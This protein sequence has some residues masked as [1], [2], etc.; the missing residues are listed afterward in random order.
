[1]SL[2]VRT[3]FS[4]I[5]GRGAIRGKKELSG[6]GSRLGRRAGPRAT[7]KNNPVVPLISATCFRSLCHQVK[8]KQKGNQVS[9][10]GHHGVGYLFNFNLVI[11]ILFPSRLGGNWDAKW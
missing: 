9:K 8:K 11:L 3:R 5:I 2:L 7:M 4:G 1:M 10:A 6:V